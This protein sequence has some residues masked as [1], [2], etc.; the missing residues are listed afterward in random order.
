MKKVLTLLAVSS[1]TVAAFGQ[2]YVN[3]GGSP[4]GDVITATNSVNYSSLASSLGGGLATGQQGA[5]Q[6]NAAGLAGNV[7]YYELLYAASGT[8]APTTLSAFSSWTATGLLMEDVLT[9]NN[10]RIT[11]LSGSSAA[12]IDPGY[13]SGT[14]AVMLVGWSA[15][16]GTT[17]AGTGGV[18]SELNAWPTGAIPNAYFGE[19][20]VGTITPSTSSASGAAVF[21]ASQTVGGLISNP[22]SSPMVMNELQAVPEP[23][24]LALVGMGAASLLAFRRR[25]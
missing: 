4:A 2:G 11:P 8:T 23:T 24:S 22:S 25:K 7:Y 17:F 6:G 13:S 18:L 20:Y 1:M 14:L 21:T 19:G 15:N 3:W 9:A 10:G 16:L 5:A 12:E